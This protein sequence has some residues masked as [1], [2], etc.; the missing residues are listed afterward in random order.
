MKLNYLDFIKSLFLYT[1]ILAAIGY[2]IV[3]L[4]PDEYVTPTLPFLYLFFFSATLL[5]HY[6][7]LKVAQKRTANF[8]NYFMLLTFGKLIFFL[9]IVLLYA[10]LRREDAAQFIITFFVLYVFFTIFEVAQSL[11][12]TKSINHKRKQD[13]QEESPGN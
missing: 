10:L 8:I 7:L 12:I 11:S 6:V 13:L 1:L 4:L 5:V 2:G 3:Y 9:S